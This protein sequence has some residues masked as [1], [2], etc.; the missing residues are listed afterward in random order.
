MCV[1]S[2]RK[3]INNNFDRIL[4]V[5]LGKKEWAQIFVISIGLDGLK[6][7]NCILFMNQGIFGRECSTIKGG[8]VGY[9]QCVNT[10]LSAAK[11]SAA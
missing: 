1:G 2:S 4:N 10:K 9:R 8:I 6:S 7:G 5:C 11:L 3:Q